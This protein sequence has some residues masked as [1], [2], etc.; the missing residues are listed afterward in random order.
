MTN[1][2]RV[3]GPVV[4]NNFGMIEV[5][6]DAKPGPLVTLSL[7]TADRADAFSYSFALDDLN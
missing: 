6:W 5:A 2:Y 3:A 7:Q 4:Q 1:T